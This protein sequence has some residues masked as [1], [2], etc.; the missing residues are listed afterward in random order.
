MPAMMENQEIRVRGAVQGVGFRPAV[1]RLAMECLLRGE[2]ANDSD[3]VL[4]RLS[5]TSQSIQNFLARLKQEAPPLAQID[6]IS[7]TKGDD[8]WDYSGFRITGSTHL[9]GSTEV[10]PDAAT[11]KACLAEINN[12]EERRFQYPFTNCTHCGPRLSII[13]GIPYDRETT[14]MASFDLCEQCK[15]E[16]ANPLD[17]RFHAQPIACHACGPSLILYSAGQTIYPCPATSSPYKQVAAQL[18]HICTVLKAGEIVAVKGLGGY[19][20]CCDAS[21]H[22]A[23][24]TLRERKQRYAKPF[25]LMTHELA[26]IK[27]YCLV[28]ELE[29]DI[30]SSSI[31]PIVL[32]EARQVIN[33]E[34]TILS[35]AIA[36][37][38]RLLGFM[39]PYTPLHHMICRQFGGPLVMTS[40]NVSGEPQVI[41]NDEAIANLSS[42]AD[43]VV[44]HN[45]AVA[46]RIDD[47]V[48]RCVAGK[49]RI[50]R[51]ARGYA[52]RSIRLPSGFETADG[53]QAYGAELKSTFCLVKQ[54]AAVLSQHQGDLEDVSTFDDYEHNLALYQRLFEFTPRYL[55]FDQHPE[56]ISSKLAK[57][58]SG[59]NG[60]PAIRIQ[61]HHAHIACVMAENQL[62]IDHSPVLGVALDGLG[63]GDDGT[64][65]G[66]E[67]L[68]ADYRTYQR[69]ARLKPVAM[70]GAGQAVKQP[71]RNAYAHILNSMDWESFQTHYGE[72][73]LAACFASHPTATLQK[74]M[75]GALNCPLASSAGRLFDAVAAA[76]GIHAEQVQFEG[77]AAIEL[78]MLVD[79]DLLSHYLADD[80]LSLSYTLIIDIP[81]IPSSGLPELN[82]ASMWPQLLDD[83]RQGISTTLISTRFHAGLIKGIVAMLLQL[84]QSYTFNDVALSGGCM[85]NAVLLEGLIHSLHKKGLNCLSHSLIPANDGGIALGQAAIAAARIIVNDKTTV[86]D[87]SHELRFTPKENVCV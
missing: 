47:S 3:G 29:K 61:H 83:V 4:I 20:L 71:W 32:L 11:C 66:G 17:R 44:C 26:T 41:D 68:L 77:Q 8:N 70:P 50:L 52:P 12:S 18:S 81:N 42:I 7:M 45:R 25:A 87:L 59:A 86:S 56:Y 16:Y 37:G 34:S 43:L 55:A 62:A 24:E 53:I 5:G 1:Y 15:V 78:E 64:L 48:V 9:R 6:S 51:R 60:M 58:D 23:V 22:A 33:P 82:A 79:K 65:W 85:Q 67:F 40:G 69:V 80:D 36:P 74:M 72:T 27:N 10:V 46:N 84:R 57:N 21:N 63:F 38:S 75:K 13:Q 39:L 31:A 28:S 49:V 76:I 30:L 73:A 19:H 2:V 54:G 14:T 35:A